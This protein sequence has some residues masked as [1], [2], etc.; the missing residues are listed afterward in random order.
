DGYS[1]GGGDVTRMVGIVE[2]NLLGTATALA[3]VY[4]NT[5]DRRTFDLG[6]VN[7][8]FLSRRGWLQAKYSNKSDGN[9]GT[10]LV[11]VPFYETAARHALTTDRE[12]ASERALVIREGV[13]DTPRLTQGQ[14][15]RAAKSLG[16]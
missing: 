3:A 7:P 2:D 14:V 4:N 15:E 5:P 1:R 9:R 16:P 6:H 8:H 12:A 11:G 13:P 10:W